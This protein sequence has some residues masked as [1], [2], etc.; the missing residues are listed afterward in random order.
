MSGH[1]KTSVWIKYDKGTPPGRREA[2]EKL[3][4]TRKTYVEGETPAGKVLIRLTQDIDRNDY[5]GQAKVLCATG[6]AQTD[7]IG[8]STCFH[9]CTAKCRDKN[10]ADLHLRSYRVT[11][12]DYVMTNG[13]T[14]GL[15][16]AKSSKASSGTGRPELLSGAPHADVLGGLSLGSAIAESEGVPPTK[17]ARLDLE[18]SPGTLG[19]TLEDRMRRW[20]LRRLAEPGIDKAERIRLM[21]QLTALDGLPGPSV[22]SGPGVSLND[23]KKSQLLQRQEMLRLYEA[24]PG[25]L[26]NNALHQF[27]DIMG[28]LDEDHLPGRRPIL[29]QYLRTGASAKV[30][31]NKRSY[32]EMMTLGTAVDLMVQ[33][34][35]D[36]ALAVLLH[37]FLAVEMAASEDAWDNAQY[38]ELLAP[39][40]EIGSSS[41]L[42]R[43][44]RAAAKDDAKYSKKEY[45]DEQSRGSWRRKEKNGGKPAAPG[46][47]GTSD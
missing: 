29:R 37:R 25:M 21:G 38:I 36:K 41:G 42:Q 10:E 24:S 34:K 27:Q 2:R 3:T 35:V 46:A 22:N 17:R 1:E 32:R 47:V 23:D 8:S 44:A 30:K 15:L 19:E 28:M 26:V 7:M 39:T 13:W 40:S 14:K 4:L 45:K 43:M 31:G 18:Q 33:G 20:I 16:V 6:Q 12:R 5:T 9:L 11:T